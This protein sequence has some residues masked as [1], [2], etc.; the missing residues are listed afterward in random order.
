[1]LQDRFLPE[2]R[3]NPAPQTVAHTASEIPDTGG[4]TPRSAD[5]GEPRPLHQAVVDPDSGKK[6]QQ[7]HPEQQHNQL[8]DNLQRLVAGEEH[9]DD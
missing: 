7:L 2:R 6:R 5:N 1:M 8:R 3:Q 4:R 9:N